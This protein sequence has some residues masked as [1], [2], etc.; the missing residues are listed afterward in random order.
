MI[1]AVGRLLVYRSTIR[2]YFSGSVEDSV[3][4]LLSDRLEKINSIFGQIPDVL[5]DVWVL[6]H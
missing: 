3:H 6:W 1:F 2:F 4:E 5:E